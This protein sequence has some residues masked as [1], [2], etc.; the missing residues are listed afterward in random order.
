MPILIQIGI[1]V[2][3]LF[4][5]AWFLGRIEH[6]AKTVDEIK[7]YIEEQKEKTPPE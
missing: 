1:I 6:I 7:T 3:C 4:I 5:L 2:I